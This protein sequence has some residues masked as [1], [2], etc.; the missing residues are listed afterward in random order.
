[1]N[2]DT[3]LNRLL[4]SVEIPP[5]STDLEHRIT[6]ATGAD[7]NALR[8][9]FSARLAVPAMAAAV[10]G[11]VALMVLLKPVSTP[12][13]GTP[14]LASEEAFI[15]LFDE[16][17]EQSMMPEIELDEEAAYSYLYGIYE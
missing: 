7:R 5:A 6:S 4:D 13:P 3:R 1:M 9:N 15:W 10:A 11:L 2:T 12:L 17:W 16:E 14:E 8:R